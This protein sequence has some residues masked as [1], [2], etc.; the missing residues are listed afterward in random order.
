MRLDDGGRRL[1]ARRSRASRRLKLTLAGSLLLHALLL[2]AVWWSR[3]EPLSPAETGNTS[4][5]VSVVFQSSG[6]KQASV[7]APDAAKE[8]AS[9][10]GNLNA[11]TTQPNP[12]TSPPAAPAPPETRQLPP[13]PAPPAPTVEPPAPVPPQPTPPTPP[14]PT[15]PTP[16]RPTTPPTVSLNEDEGPAPPPPF[17]MPQPPLPLPPRPLAPPRQTS[18]R[19]PSNPFAALRDWSLNAQPSQRSPG[20]ASRGLDVSPDSLSGRTSESLGYVSGAKPTG[21]WIGSL[22]RWVQARTYYP[23][24]AVIEGQQGPATVEV[25]IARSGKVL[26]FRLVESSRSAFLDGGWL[27]VWR[28]STAPPFTPDMQGDSTTIV[29]TMNYILTGRR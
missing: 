7:K 11:T 22:K 5:D 27:D 3:P 6:E 26:S 15:T 12:D 10:Q 9:P 16:P 21:D 20:R 24:E 28:G 1:R 13:E 2:L 4:D 18:Q 19:S 8:Q 29:F 23:E 17:V 25:Q 14:Q